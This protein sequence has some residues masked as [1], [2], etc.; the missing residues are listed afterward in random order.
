MMNDRN[1]SGD[2]SKLLMQNFMKNAG[3][4]S[5]GNYD[6]ISNQIVNKNHKEDTTVDLMKKKLLKKKNEDKQRSNYLNFT[7]PIN[8]LNTQINKTGPLGKNNVN[9]AENNHLQQ[10]SNVT[11][12]S[13]SINSSNFK[14]NVT[15]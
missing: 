8:Q 11:P 4:G 14:L 6:N 7:N 13:T 3:N 15:K 9:S 10:I 2:K 5:S 1:F 12:N